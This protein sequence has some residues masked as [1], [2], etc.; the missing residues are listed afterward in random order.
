MLPVNDDDLA[1][2]GIDPE[3]SVVKLLQLATH[4][5]LLKLEGF[6]CPLYLNAL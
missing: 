4:L 1:L 3:P 2:A 5:D 6:P